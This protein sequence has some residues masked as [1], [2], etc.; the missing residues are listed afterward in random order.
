MILIATQKEAL[1]INMSVQITEAQFPAIQ[2]NSSQI[3]TVVPGT[4]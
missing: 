3:P 4:Q 1:N 2:L